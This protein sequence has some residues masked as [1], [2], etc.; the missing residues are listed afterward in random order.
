MSEQLGGKVRKSILALQGRQAL[1]MVMNLGV[2]IILSRELTPEI[3]GLYG[4]AMFC[5]SIITMATDFGL[6]GSLVQRKQDFGEHEV[7][8]AFTLQAVVAFSSAALLWLLAPLAML[9]YK[10]ADPDLVW[11]IRSLAVPLVLS[12]IAAT[13][14]L[15]LEREIKFDKIAVIDVVTMVV[16]NAVV[17]WM[18]FAGYGVWSFVWGNAVGGV[19]TAMISWSLISYRPRIRFDLKLTKELLSFGVY[20]QFSTITNDAAGW[21]VPLISGASLGPAAVGLLTWASSNGRRP[22]MIVESVM[23]VAFPHF[24]RLQDQR[25]ELGRQVG[26]Y[27]RRLLLFCYAWALLGIVLGET[28]TRLVYTDKWLPGLQALQL[29]AIGLALDV[30]NWVG[31]MTL[32]ALGGVKETAK[33]TTVKAALAIGGSFVFLHAFGMVGIP[34]ASIVASLVSGAG[35]MYHLR[36]RIPL[37]S[38]DMVLPAIP[39]LLLGAVY[40]PFVLLDLPAR[41]IAAWVVGAIAIAWTTFKGLRE[42]RKEPDPPMLPEA[43]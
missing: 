27:F 42:L 25:E 20:F 19:V 24:S 10:D 26:N 11:I 18:V 17:L 35:I 9:V 33:W 7:C 23:R 43:A 34:M 22:L 4:I 41:E 32:N 31:G 38:R 1:I 12:P 6:A 29:F 2:G 40:A 28:M 39:F 30:A 5:L 15:Q 21:I 8:V 3:F 16:G 13:A 14:K 36:R 37:R